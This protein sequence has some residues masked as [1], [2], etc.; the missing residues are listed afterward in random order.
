NDVGAPGMDYR[1]FQ[2]V[3]I[4]V[5]EGFNLYVDGKVNGTPAQLM[6]DTGAFATL[7]HRSFVKQMKIPTRDTP[8]S[9]AAVNL[10][11]RGVQVA[12]IRSLS[13]GKVDFAGRNVG[14]IDLSGLIYQRPH[15]GAKPIA[16]LLG[17]ELLQRHH[18]IIDFGTRR[19]YLKR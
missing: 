1:G 9:S 18:G 19:L 6:V 5:T 16:G 14:V 7:L 3:P 4:H 11:E 12:R 8:F 17:A 2:S 13:V 15:E 10:R